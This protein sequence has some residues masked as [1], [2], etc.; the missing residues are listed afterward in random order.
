[1]INR[2]KRMIVAPL[3]LMGSI[4][5]NILLNLGKDKYKKKQNLSVVL[6]NKYLNSFK[7]QHNSKKTYL[8][9]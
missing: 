6:K 7:K 3:N 8:T 5:K 9:K 4:K 1:M 2:I